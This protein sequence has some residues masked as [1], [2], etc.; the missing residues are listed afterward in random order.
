M[1]IDDLIV[2][3]FGRFEVLLTHYA[4][5]LS[6]SSFLITSATA[7]DRDIQISFNISLTQKIIIMYCEKRQQYFVKQS[8]QNV[9][10][11]NFCTP[12]GQIWLKKQIC[13]FKIKFRT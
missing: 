3:Y 11:Q 4:K 10:L 9:T 6:G 8:T 13:L 12:S 1:L 2:D 7:V 5:A